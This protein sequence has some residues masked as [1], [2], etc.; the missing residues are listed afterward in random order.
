[1]CDL[2]EQSKSNQKNILFFFLKLIK[3][4]KYLDYEKEMGWLNLATDIEALLPTSS[5]KYYDT[6]LLIPVCPQTRYLRLWKRHSFFKPTQKEGK[7]LKLCMTSRWISA[8]Y[9]NSN[10]N[11]K[12][13]DVALLFV[14]VYWMFESNFSIL[15]AIQACKSELIARTWLTPGMCSCNHSTWRQTGRYMEFAGQITHPIRL[16]PDSVRDL[17]SN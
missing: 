1:M 15:F 5:L 14:E 10:N 8:N 7:Y 16:A 3:T 2:G 12:F 13:S 9:E 17:V 4:D 11:E 6:V